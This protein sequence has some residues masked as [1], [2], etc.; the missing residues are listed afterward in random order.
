MK[1]FPCP[2]SLYCHFGCWTCQKSHN[3]L[4]LLGVRVWSWRTSICLKGPCLTEGTNWC[5]WDQTFF[6]CTEQCFGQ[7]LENI[8]VTKQSTPG[9]N[10]LPHTIQWGSN[11]HFKTASYR[12]YSTFNPNY[13]FCKQFYTFSFLLSSIALNPY[14]SPSMKRVC[15]CLCLFIVHSS[16]IWYS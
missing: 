14:Y 12:D 15:V 4:G 7:G 9:H 11:T 8:F 10:S 6:S 2:R 16:C 13:R 1:A 3:I 5:L